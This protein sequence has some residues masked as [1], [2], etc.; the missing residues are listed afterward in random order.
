MTIL[1]SVWGAQH[2]IAGQYIQQM[3]IKHPSLRYK[4]GPSEYEAIV[5]TTKQL[6]HPMKKTKYE[7]KEKEKE[8]SRKRKFTNKHRLKKGRDKG[9]N[10]EMKETHSEK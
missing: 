2:P 10:K 5:L 9:R 3:L 6:R 4:P 7:C 1:T 8:D